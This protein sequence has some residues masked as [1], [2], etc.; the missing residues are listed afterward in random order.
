MA[1]EYITSN[2]LFEKQTYM[3]SEY[4]GMDFLNEYLDSRRECL[5]QYKDMSEGYISMIETINS[6][7]QRKLLKVRRCL[8]GKK[9]NRQI[10]K[11]MDAYTKTFEVR[12]RIYTNYD[13]NWKPLDNAGFEEYGVYLILADC[14]IY[15]YQNTKCLK[16]FNCLL[17]LNDSL[18]SLYEQLEDKYKIWLCWII[19]Q[20]QNIFLLLLKENDL[21]W[22]MEK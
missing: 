6:P 16:Y 2:N 12:K 10:K 14:L 21:Y 7:T 19:R 8:R 13:D 15:A 3:Y 11:I 18:L 22:E 20:E 17:K 4:R 9:W 5:E 1:Y